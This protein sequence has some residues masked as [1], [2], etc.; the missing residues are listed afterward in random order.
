[1]QAF[2]TLSGP[3]IP[4]GAA[5]IDTDVIIPARFLKTVTRAGLGQGAFSVLRETPDNVFDNHA[6]APILIAGANFG[7]GS[8][9]E[10]APWALADLGIRV[11]ISPGFADIFAGNAFKNGLLLVTLPQDAV[12][13]LLAVARDGQAITVDL[14]NQVVTTPFQDRFEFAMDPFRKHCLVN[15]LDEI[16]LTLGLGDA[17]AA[18][19][20]RLAA[21][22]PW[23]AGA[24]G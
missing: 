5:N 9:R 12:D 22:R 19:E 3:A 21:E 8:S 4:F 17:I 11:V 20:T 1:M 18:H 6:G 15:G 2:T 23:I 13:R 16:G 24:A 14:E 10:H 7:C